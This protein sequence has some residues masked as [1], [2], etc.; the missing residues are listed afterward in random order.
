MGKRA[1]I[2]PTNQKVFRFL[3]NRSKAAQKE[4]ASAAP[5]DPTRDYYRGAGS[6][7]EI[8]ERIWDQLGKALPVESR[9][10]VFGTPALVHPQSGVVLAFALGTAYALRLPKELTPD[11]RPADLR[12]V[13]NWTG[14]D[15]TDVAR[16]CGSDWIFGS[17]AAAEIGWCQQAFQE[18]TRPA[19]SPERGRSGS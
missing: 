15:S 13:V 6:H 16:E 19:V 5:D 12:T 2:D 8:V 7:P 1:K 11:R 3:K 14:G 18:A 10:L 4:P 9:A 17:F